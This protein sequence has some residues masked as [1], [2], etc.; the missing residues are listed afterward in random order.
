MI[1]PRPLSPRALTPLFLL[2]IIFLSAA[3]TARAGDNDWKPIDPADLAMKTSIVEPSADA[4]ALFWE[5][6]LDDG[7]QDLVLTHYVRTKI[8]TERG[9]ESQSK[10]E[11]RYGKIYGTNT[12]LKDIEARTITP[13][14]Q[15]VQLKKDDIFERTEVKTS[16]VKWKVKSFAMPAVVPGAIIEYR[17]REVREGALANRI[18]LYFQRDIP[19]QRVTY[20]LKPNAYIPYAMRF[21]T[22][23]LDDAKPVKEKNGFYSFTQ[24]K[25]P[26]F[27]EEPR[28][29]AAADVRSWMLVYYSP[30]NKIT[31]QQYWRETGRAQF[32]AFKKIM[33]PDDA[34]RL[35]AT[36][37]VGDAKTPDEKLARLLTFCRTQIK[38]V[39]TDDYG[40]RLDDE[41]KVKENKSPGD[42]LKRGMG[43]RGDIDMLF[44]ALAS[45]LG[46]EARLAFLGDRSEG[47]FDPSFADSHFLRTWS[48]AVRAE[49]GAAWRFFDPCATYIAPGMLPWVMEGQT[50]LVT[51]AKEPQFVATQV[52][53]PKESVERRT[54]K[55]RLTEDGTLEGDVR[56]EYTGHF[57]AIRKEYNDDEAPADRERILRDEIKEQMSTAELT[58]I[59][60][61]NVTDPI[62]PFAYS[63]HIR[64]PAY[65]QRTGKR[66]FIQPAFF[67]K[68][69]SPVF[70]TSTRTHPVHFEHGWTEEDVVT[71]DLPTGFTLD[72]ADMP[73]PVTAG[74]I[75]KYEAR[76]QLASGAK[77]D[78]QLIFK[79]NFYFGNGGL[80]QF[81]TKTYVQLKNY[82]DMVYEN[83]KH[84]IALRAAPTTAAK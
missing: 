3:A 27:R 74:A 5:V 76:A 15:I 1:F 37:I 66:L 12:R 19:V 20:F 23:R 6:R 48:I 33:K 38:D 17:W 75:S 40:A 45:A 9:R 83:D 46:Y 18:P 56:V 24:T 49:P 25:M 55:L 22:F 16:G 73:Q 31:P 72:N 47:T 51:D 28:M 61:E 71:I 36:E 53:D 13:D 39:N 42:T 62:K 7:T 29:P 84:T 34:V 64:V 81:D 35:K 8:F 69:K 10:V 43:T 11:L 30:D 59:R 52:A 4:E 50:A 79:R 80:L 77:N 14:G 32:D 2:T 70:K 68:D 54:A 67:Q 60:I 58:D 82:F 65:A 21:Q 57:A 26:A 78:N 44:A 41:I 63:Y